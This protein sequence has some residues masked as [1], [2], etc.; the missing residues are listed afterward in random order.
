MSEPIG[1]N[2]AIR[3]ANE[4]MKIFVDDYVRAVK[5][6]DKVEIKRHKD[7]LKLPTDRRGTWWNIV[8]E[9]MGYNSEIAANKLLKFL[10]AID[11]QYALDKKQA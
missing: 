10:E 7:Y 11:K 5:T 2:P 6:E 9:V 4:M 8:C 3:F 1:F